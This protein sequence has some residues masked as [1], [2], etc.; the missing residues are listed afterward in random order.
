MPNL[1]SALFVKQKLAIL[2]AM[3]MH[4]WQFEFSLQLLFIPPFSTFCLYRKHNKISYLY[5]SIFRH[6]A[7][8]DCTSFVSFAKFQSTH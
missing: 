5:M 1:L 8:E 4:R 2:L 7:T 3:K 6:S